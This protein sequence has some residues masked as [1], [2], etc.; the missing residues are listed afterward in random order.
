M[1]PLRPGDPAG[2]GPFRV[3]A[4]LGAGGM[5]VVYL[6]RSPSGAVAAVKVIHAAHVGD[7][8]FRA[9]FRREVDAARGVV[10]PWVAPLLDADPDAREP[11]L[12]TAF[13]PGPSLAEAV[14]L[15]GPLPHA[16]VRFLGARLAEA[17]EAVHR[18]GL[19]H[20][21]VKPGNILLGVDGPRLIDFGIARSDDATALTSSGMVVGSP[22]FLSPEQA[23]ARP[24]EIGPPSDVFSLGCVLAYAAAG[25]RPFGGGLAAAALLRAVTEEP[26]LDGVPGELTPLLRA[27]LAKQPQHRPGPAAVR[28]AL[29]GIQDAAGPWLPEPVVR[30][31]ADRS[32]QVL[33]IAAAGGTTEV[34]PPPQ[35]PKARLADAETVTAVPVGTGLPGIP[36]RR[37]FLALGSAAGAAA[38]G[39]GAL[40]WVRT[41]PGTSGAERDAA[42]DRPV[43]T[44]ALHGDLS[45]AAAAAGQA[46]RNGARIAVD[47]VNARRSTP[48]RLALTVHDDGGV[49]S[50]AAGVAR[51]L[52]GDASVR[53]VVGPTTDACALAAVLTYHE[54]SLPTVAVSPG[55]DANRRIVEDVNPRAYIPGRVHD[56]LM[57]VPCITHLSRTVGA[58]RVVILDDRAQGDLSWNICRQVATALRNAG[59]TA[60]VRAV[61]QAMNAGALAAELKAAR[62]DALLF[63]GDEL[64]AASLARALASTGY[65]GARMGIRQG[66]GPRFLRTAGVTAE[67]W[68][69][70]TPFVEAARTPAAREFTATYRGKFGTTPPWWAAEAYD[71]VL[72]IADAMTDG[73]TPVTDRGSII[74]RAQEIRY[75][76]ITRT[77]S[78]S[79]ADGGAYD[80]EGLFLHQ[81]RG[82]TFA[83]LGQYARSRLIKG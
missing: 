24:A 58:R 21:D 22:G 45:G 28:A 47:D 15:H 68:V 14:G 56:Q 44:L 10:S 5:G 27:C 49:P 77:L 43:L 73:R 33:R 74:R 25:V 55:V 62:A 64:R 46:Q 71:A 60:T 17:L 20:R 54:A 2:A 63:T 36:T 51:R 12:A 34:P 4:R 65:T 52:V 41:R 1:R 53:A 29:G 9:R 8:A 6:A 13:V 19:V 31:I 70:T 7:A 69:F 37:R 38:A 66:F 80:K 59:R 39:A 78:Y 75:H 32:A 35:P 30:L 72:F 40:W 50:R 82:G 83:F 57:A 81:V 26:D 42:Q 67:G 48:F 18:A 61:G 76:G 11:W 79:V 16:T 23:Q 3:L